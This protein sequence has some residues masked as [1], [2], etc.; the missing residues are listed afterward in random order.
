MKLELGDIKMDSE[1]SIQIGHAAG[2]VHAEQRCTQ[3]RQIMTEAAEFPR[4]GWPL[5]SIAAH[6]VVT[7][8]LGLI[9]FVMVLNGQP[10]WLILSV[11]FALQI[12]TAARVMWALWN[13]DHQGNMQG[14]QSTPDKVANDQ[15]RLLEHFALHPESKTVSEIQNALAWSED[16]AL[17][18]IHNL[19][20]SQELDEDVDLDTGRF[21]YRKAEKFYIEPDH[22]SATERFHQTQEQRA[23]SKESK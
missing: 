8:L 16:T 15:K 4:K 9:A 5:V 6:G 21:V 19:L 17:E 23:I 12:P 10:L 22:T 14:I 11:F 1:G 3:N 13:K 18:V 20:V 7:L 2:V